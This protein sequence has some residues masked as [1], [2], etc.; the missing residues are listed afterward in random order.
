M[1]EIKIEDGN[2]ADCIC[3]QKTEGKD[4]RERACS[5]NNEQLKEMISQTQHREV[6]ADSVSLHSLFSWDC[7]RFTIQGI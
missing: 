2:K 4:S 7:Y 5:K 1:I 6:I 3:I